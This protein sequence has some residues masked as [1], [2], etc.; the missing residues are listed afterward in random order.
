MRDGSEVAF[1]HLFHHYYPLLSNYALRF[2]VDRHVIEEC[3]QELFIKI[4]QH[5]EN[6][7]QPASIK[8]Y[9]FKS[10][11]HTIYNKL[12]ARRPELYIGSTDDF[13]EFNLSYNQEDNVYPLHGLSDEMLQQSINQLTARQREAI[14]LFYFEDLGYQEIADVLQI[15]IGGAYKLIYRA[16]DALKAH[17]TQSGFQTPPVPEEKV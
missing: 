5:R 14:F 13:L 11:R 1:E 2:N 12:S 8:H 9:L 10:L 3:I 16:I 15:N 7:K 17:Y 6:L 4:W